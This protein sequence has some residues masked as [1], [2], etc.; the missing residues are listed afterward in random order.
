ML[1]LVFSL[2]L[3]ES[4]FIVGII[5]EEILTICNYLF[6]IVQLLVKLFLL[7]LLLF[8]LWEISTTIPLLRISIVG[9]FAATIAASKHPL[10]ITARDGILNCI[11]KVLFKSLVTYKTV[12]YKTIH[13]QYM[14]LRIKDNLN[15]HSIENINNH[16]ACFSHC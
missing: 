12:T 10:T 7:F 9:E 1:C 4:F 5:S 11:R 3:K 8:F 16:S 6:I 14:E 2:L 13:Q 15:Y